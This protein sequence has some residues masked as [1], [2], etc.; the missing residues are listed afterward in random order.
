MGFIYRVFVLVGLEW[1]LGICD[2][3]KCLGDV[4]VVG[5]GIIFWE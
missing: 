1:G 3:N 4:E 2:V 5:L